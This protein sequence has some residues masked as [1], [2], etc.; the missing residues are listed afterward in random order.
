MGLAWS[1]AGK[2]EKAPNM[3][4]LIDHFN[5]MSNYVRDQILSRDTVEA[6]VEV[7]VF[8]TNVCVKL[9]EL[10]NYNGAMEVWCLAGEQQNQAGKGEGG[11]ESDLWTP[12]HCNNWG[13]F[14]GRGD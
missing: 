14:S 7:M 6:R 5:K 10:Q 9:Y 2:E 3:L 12:S 8:F 1:K 4:R 13:R 11:M